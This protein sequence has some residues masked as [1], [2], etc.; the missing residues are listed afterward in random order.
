MATTTSPPALT[1]LHWI[2]LGLVSVRKIGVPEKLAAELDVDVDQVETLCGD[3]EMLGWI[4]RVE[5]H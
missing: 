2:L 5:V 4:E 1:S 3:L